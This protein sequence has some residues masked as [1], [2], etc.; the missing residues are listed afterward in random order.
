MLGGR[1]AHPSLYLL[2]SFFFDKFSLFTFLLFF[3]KKNI[4]MI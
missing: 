2:I 4:H 1:T 3:D